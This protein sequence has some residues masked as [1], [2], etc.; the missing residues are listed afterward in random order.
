MIQYEW[1]GGP[2]Q[3][4]RLEPNVTAGEY[5]IVAV[6]SGKVLDVQGISTANGAN[7]QQWDW[8]GGFNQLWRFS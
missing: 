6:H 7:I 8:V 5:R 3:R 4:F 1:H 2:N